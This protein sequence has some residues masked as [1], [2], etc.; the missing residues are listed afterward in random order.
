MTE[1]RPTARVA[2]LWNFFL[3]AIPFL[4]LLPLL[5]VTGATN[6]GPDAISYLRIATYYAEG[7]YELA[8][9]GYWGPL[10]SWLMVPFLSL[11]DNH[12]FAAARIAM[13]LSAVLFVAASFLV[14]RS[15]RL[16]RLQI[17][18]ATTIIALFALFRAVDL[19]TPDL[20]M[21]SFILLAL[22]ATL[23]PEIHSPW[24]YFRIGLIYGIAYLAK[25]IALPLAI[26][27]VIGIYVF[28]ALV[29]AMT[30]L[31]AAR[32]AGALLAGIMVV[33][34]PWILILSLHYGTPTFSTS[35]AIAHALIG[36]GE[37]NT[38][39]PSF[40][41][42]HVPEPG[43]ITSW[44]EPSLMAY[45]HWS[46][47]ANAGNFRHQMSVVSRNIRYIMTL[48]GDFDW[49]GLGV[50]SALCGFLF[51]RP[52]QDGFRRQPWR[53]APLV[54][55]AVGAAYAPVFADTSRY[56]FLCYPLLLG[57]AFAFLND[58]T[59]NASRAP[60]SVSRPHFS[61][62]L[63]TLVVAGSFLVNLFPNVWWT[64]RNDDAA[65]EFRRAEELSALL[66]KEPEG[67]IASVGYPVFY[68]GVHTAFLSNRAYYGNR[69]DTPLPEEIISAGIAF[70]VV[71]AGSP[72]DGIL[73]M[74]KRFERLSGPDATHY[75][76]QLYRVLAPN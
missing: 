59:G 32:A 17:V 72:M 52:W 60:S 69:V 39:H 6:R 42:F 25:S 35:G 56:Y 57:C 1:S 62:A 29:G 2:A 76:F 7:N 70:L 58:I 4:I 10:L 27:I 26:A 74:D 67:P 34:A 46:P 37:G 63:I 18:A 31:A 14:F 44:E 16:P 13:A 21:A 55:A 53:C 64:V 50:A 75:P 8:V 23:A 40:R 48:L 41:E 3:Y 28:R 12:A 45:H 5:A 65:P 30:A 51:H 54:I 19:I 43:R 49:F 11:V 9:N 20:L 33:A 22:S 47:F 71:G 68:A 66:A 73:A 61:R 38:V 24:R 36:P 15:F